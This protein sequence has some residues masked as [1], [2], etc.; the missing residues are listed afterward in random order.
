M[1]KNYSQKHCSEGYLNTNVTFFFSFYK[2]NIKTQKIQIEDDQKTC[3]FLF[4]FSRHPDKKKKKKKI[5][6][7][8]K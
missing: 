8:Q 5:T 2:I 6:D 4:S 7:S 3:E 1:K